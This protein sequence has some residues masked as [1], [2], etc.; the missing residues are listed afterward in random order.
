MTNAERDQLLIR[1]RNPSEAIKYLLEV[2]ENESINSLMM[3]V[4]LIVEA[5]SFLR[6]K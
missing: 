3:C 4:A 6:V 1:L 2:N 5:N